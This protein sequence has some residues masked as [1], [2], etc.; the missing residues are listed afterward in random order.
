[1]SCF[2]PSPVVPV[3]PVL[4]ALTA[5]VVPV[6]PVALVPVVGLV[7]TSPLLCVCPPEADAVPVVGVVSPVV[8]TVALPPELAVGSVALAGPTPVPASPVEPP[9]LSPHPDIHPTQ[10]RPST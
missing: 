3:S 9:P 6:V 4:D 5:P 7:V 10:A 8:G 1:M 2:G